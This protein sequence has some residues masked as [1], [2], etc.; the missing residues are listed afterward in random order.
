MHH[1]VPPDQ[2]PRGARLHQEQR[3]P[4]GTSGQH[5]AA[6]AVDV[7]PPG[8]AIDGGD[9]AR[10]AVCLERELFHLDTGQQ[11]QRQAFSGR[12]ADKLPRAAPGAGRADIPGTGMAA[13]ATPGINRQR[14]P[15]RPQPAG[16][17]GF[18]EPLVDGMERQRLTCVPVERL[19]Q[20]PKVLIAAPAHSEQPFGPRVIRGQ[21]L[22]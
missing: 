8:R 1:I 11:L 13:Q 19:A 14:Q 2:L 12:L 17:A 9:A 22:V 6:G 10:I 18:H 4:N 15:E 16:P 5:V 20:W 3:R 7:A 21:D